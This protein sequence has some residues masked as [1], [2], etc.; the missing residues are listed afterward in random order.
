MA[1]FLAEQSN[2]LTQ[3][4]SDEVITYQEESPPHKKKSGYR[5]TIT[6][7]AE[8]KQRMQWQKANYISTP[9]YNLLSSDLRVEEMNVFTK[10]T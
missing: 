5:A 9:W 8:D 10:T 1:R 7:T 6:L 2:A 4:I 3:Y